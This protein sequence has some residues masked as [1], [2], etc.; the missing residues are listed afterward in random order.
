[1]IVSIWSGVE[2]VLVLQG[3]GWETLIR[4]TTTLVVMWLVLWATVLFITGFNRGSD[5]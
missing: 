4:A 3:A 2:G 1:L 5:R